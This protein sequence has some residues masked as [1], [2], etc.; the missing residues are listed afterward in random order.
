[1]DD[2]EDFT[3]FVASALRAR[4]P[5]LKV[6]VARH[7]AEAIEMIRVDG[8]PSLVLSDYTMPVMDGRE[9]GKIL[10]Q[11]YGR[12]VQ[13]VL[14]TGQPVDNRLPMDT[15]GILAKPFDLSTI[16]SRID[17]FN[18]LPKE[19]VEGRKM[20]HFSAKAKAARGKHGIVIPRGSIEQ[21]AVDPNAEYDVF[22][23]KSTKKK[24]T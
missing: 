21:G 9:L 1:V 19:K 6:D 15:D 13:F 22:L 24:S 18:L 5:S 7:G 2:D 12:K 23:K 8:V 17:A 4:Y 10:K 11:T 16:Y 3:A 14:M 20:L